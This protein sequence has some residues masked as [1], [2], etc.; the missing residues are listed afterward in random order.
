VSRLVRLRWTLILF[1]GWPVPGIVELCV[2]AEPMVLWRS[3]FFSPS[4]KKYLS[5]D[6]TSQTKLVVP[7][8]A[9]RA[10]IFARLRSSRKKRYY[11]NRP[12]G[13]RIQGLKVEDALVNLENP[14]VFA[15]VVLNPER[16]RWVDS[17]FPFSIKATT[18]TASSDD[19]DDA[20]GE[21]E[22]EETWAGGQREMG[23]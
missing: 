7:D 23:K 22:E 3:L 19:D 2:G 21:E 10:A 8:R 5:S 13:N 9:A 1:N 16:M 11:K 17:F 12:V 15:R 4:P 6:K 14:F 18:A 20:Q